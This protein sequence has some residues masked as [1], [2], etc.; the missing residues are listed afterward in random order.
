MIINVDNTLSSNDWWDQSTDT[1]NTI[2]NEIKNNWKMYKYGK[3]AFISF[4]EWE[5]RELEQLKKENPEQFR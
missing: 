3:S 1:Y 2:Q 4:S 5:N